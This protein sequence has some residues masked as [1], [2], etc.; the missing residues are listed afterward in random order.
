MPELPEV[1]TIKRAVEQTF[2]NARIIGAEVRQPKLRESVAPDFAAQITGAKI[3]RLWR[4][5]KYMLTD[6]DNG[7]T[8]IW[9]FGMSGKIKME[10]STDFA[11]E[12]HDHIIIK[13]D[14]GILIYNDPR[15]FGLVRLCE[16]SKLLQCAVFKH[17]GLDPWDKNLTSAYL[18]TKFARKKTS[19]KQALLDQEIICGIGNIYA[20]E[21]LYHARIRPDRSCESLK[22][23]DLEAVILWTRK[24]LEEAVAA[25]GSTIHDYRHPDGDIGYFQEKHCV[26]NKTGQKC[27]ECRCNILK[28]GGIQKIVQNG[29]S[30]FYCATL[31]K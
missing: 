27:S 31:Q 30:T 19:V 4:L 8:V 20:S 26:Y 15:R 5:A 16:S 23:K 2:L 28:T 25:G 12:K 29:R 21:I 7:L 17:I 10:S 3:I 6:L 1:E 22:A 24:V 11:L 9:H 18:Q 14:K 13:T